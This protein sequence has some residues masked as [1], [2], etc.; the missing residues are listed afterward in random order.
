VWRG[1]GAEAEPSFQESTDIRAA[2][3]EP[4]ARAP[5]YLVGSYLALARGEPARRLDALLRAGEL[6]EAT[7]TGPLEVLLFELIRARLGADLRSETE[8]WA[9][10]LRGLAELGPVRRPSDHRARGL[11][12]EDPRR[13]LGLLD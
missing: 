4:Q 7:Q 2:N 6:V 5:L 13:R 9:R 12:A 10:Q 1:E 3:P 8:R 11:L